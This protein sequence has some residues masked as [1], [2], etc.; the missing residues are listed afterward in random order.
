MPNAGGRPEE[1]DA[2]SRR[3]GLSLNGLKARSKIY[4]NRICRLKE[5]LLVY[6][7][8]RNGEW[9]KKRRMLKKAKYKFNK[10]MKA[11]NKKF[12]YCFGFKKNP[13]IEQKHLNLLVI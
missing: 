2:R 13:I 10:M 11:S 7:R 9:F 6:K 4:I 12:R 5:S 8:P 3:S 1:D